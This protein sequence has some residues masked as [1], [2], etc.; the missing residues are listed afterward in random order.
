[1]FNTIIYTKLYVFPF[2]FIQ[3]VYFFDDIFWDDMVS[4]KLT[5][6]RSFRETMFYTG[7]SRQCV[8]EYM[9]YSHI[10]PS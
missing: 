4:N 2:Y 10:S 3:P 9:N 7:E 1:M 5:C 8:S 6:M